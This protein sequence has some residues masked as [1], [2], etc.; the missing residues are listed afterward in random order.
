MPIR[1]DAWIKIWYTYTMEYYSA[2]GKDEILPLMTTCTDLERIMH[3][4]M[5][6]KEGHIDFVHIRIQ[7][8]K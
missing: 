8:N 4:E 2:I 5:F 6:D 3:S 7:K 1:G